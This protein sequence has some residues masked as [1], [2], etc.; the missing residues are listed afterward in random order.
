MTVFST[1]WDTT[2][3]GLPSDN[4]DLA[5][6]ASRIRTLKA[7]IHERLAVDHSWGG[8]A[9]DGVHIRLSLGVSVLNV[10]SADPT[11]YG[12]LFSKFVSGGAELCWTDL[13]GNTVQLTR[14]GAVNATGGGVTGA[15]PVGP[16]VG[17]CYFD[18]TLFKPVFWSGIDWRDATGVV[19]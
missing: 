17:F 16:Q 1:T 5:L 9:A 14:A 8:N 10:A 2:F 3:E 12:A 18:T 11:T 19:A 15:R 4:E 7:A 6:G 13:S